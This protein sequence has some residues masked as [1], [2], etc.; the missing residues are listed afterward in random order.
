MAEARR[1]QL[2]RIQGPNA[3]GETVG[4]TRASFPDPQNFSIVVDAALQYLQ[5]DN[6]IDDLGVVT[7]SLPFVVSPKVRP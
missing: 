5:V 7:P 6:L 4:P 3:S 2:G 1:V